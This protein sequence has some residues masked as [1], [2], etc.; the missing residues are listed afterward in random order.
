MTSKYTLQGDRA[1]RHN[2][3]LLTI[4]TD[5]KTAAVVSGVF[6]RIGSRRDDWNV[7]PKED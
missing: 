5:L 3:L 2:K 7:K 4:P 6:D 1:D